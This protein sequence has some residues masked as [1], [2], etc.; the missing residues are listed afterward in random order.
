MCAGARDWLARRPAAAVDC[1]QCFRSSGL[2]RN[3]SLGCPNGTFE[4]VAEAGALWRPNQR[5]TWAKG[6]NMR[7]PAG[8]TEAAEAADA[9]RPLLYRQAP[10][11]ASSRCLSIFRFAAHDGPAR[12]SEVT[13][14]V[15]SMKRRP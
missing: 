10:S 6:R 4:E 1:G 2:L 7:R 13:V 12:G 11:P 15:M 14:N 9:P 8:E 5:T 3:R